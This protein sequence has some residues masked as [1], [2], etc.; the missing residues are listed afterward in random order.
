MIV[1]ILQIVPW[2]RTIKPTTQFYVSLITIFS[3]VFLPQTYFF[4]NQNPFLWLVNFILNKS[5]R[6]SEYLRIFIFKSFVFFFR[7]S[8]TFNLVNFINML[9]IT[10]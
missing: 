4:L 3:S 7:G 5:H 1:S 6:V 2:S 8:I 9:I 10:C